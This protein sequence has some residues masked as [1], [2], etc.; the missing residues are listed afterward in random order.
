[1]SPS[2]T[3]GELLRLLRDGQSRTRAELVAETGL[4][5]STVRARLDAL[6]DAGL[7]SDR[8]NGASTGGRPASR[9]VFNSRSRL[10]LAAEVGATHA[11]VAVTDLTGEPLATERIDLD[12]AD[13]PDIVLGTLAATWRG[14]VER[15]GA[16][17]AG[18]GIGLPGPVEHSTGRPTNPPIMPGWNGYDVPARVQRD[19]AVPVLVDNEVN[20]MAL[21]EHTRCHPTEQHMIVV[22][23]AT[24]I[25]SGLIS[26]GALHR[27]AV[28]AAGDLGHILAPGAGDVPCRC[29]NTGC[30]EAVASGPA[31]AAQL[32]AV[33]IPARTS[34]DVVELVQ[35]GNPTAGQA[36]RQAGRDIG[37][38]LAG[39]VSLFNPSLIVMGGS[40]SQAGEMLL[41]GVREA[42][43]R[44]SLPLATEHLRIVPSQTADSAAMLGAAAMVVQHAL[45]PDVLDPELV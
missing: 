15:H 14:L 2:A 13:G 7:V 16:P 25:G 30:L 23:V 38:V 34:K 4:A 37:E 11:T 22:K 10:V 3:P 9:F 32:T 19:F 21:G 29:G 12:I 45:S 8:G 40:L 42:I 26:N 20:L 17:V 27:G 33:G 28:G 44:R 1:M 18:I 36:V 24:G 43:Y 39:G 41:A 5:R 31:I 35:A 6:V